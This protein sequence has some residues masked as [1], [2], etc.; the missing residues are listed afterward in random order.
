MNL[1]DL[2][3]VEVEYIHDDA[4][5]LKVADD[6]FI[7]RAGDNLTLSDLRINIS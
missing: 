3:V 4:V 1:G 5:H 7:L 6:R 2:V